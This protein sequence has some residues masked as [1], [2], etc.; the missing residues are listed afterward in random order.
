MNI[1]GLA[2]FI[3]GKERGFRKFRASTFMSVYSAA[4]LVFVLLGELLSII[5]KGGIKEMDNVYIF[6]TMMKGSA[7][8]I[9][10]SG[11]LF[12][13]L[14]FRRKILNFLH[15]LLTFN[16]SIH[17]IFVSYGR[18]FNYVIAQVFVLV[19]VSALCTILIALSFQDTDFLI[20]CVFFSMTVSMLSVNLVTLLFINL[21]VVLKGCFTRINTCLCELVQCAGEESV[22]LYRQISTVKQ[23]QPVM[24]VNNKSDRPK[25]RID[26]IRRGCDF[27]CDFVDLLNSVY[28]AHTL[29]LVAFYVVIFIY[30]S[31]FGF[32]GVMDVNRGVLGTVVWVRVT[33]IETAFNAAGFTVL[34]YF[35]SSTTCEVRRC[36]YFVLLP[37]ESRLSDLNLTQ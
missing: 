22:G 26:H 36:T 16:S 17:K 29:I 18:N 15:M 4:M 32:V 7:Y 10:H 5:W 12:F 20:A 34:I 21:A 28:S 24:K 13:T 37:G 14:L 19:A 1:L 23:P 2:P 25:I 31:Y 35:C 11:F 30:D 9:S 27:L 6:A 3:L 33:C 8:I